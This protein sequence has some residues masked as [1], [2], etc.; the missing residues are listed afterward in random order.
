MREITLFVE[1]VA[2]ETFLR[3]LVQRVADECSVPVEIRFRS[4]RGGFSRVLRELERYIRDIERGVEF[5]PHLLIICTDG[6]CKGY[7]ARRQEIERAI[8]DHDGTYICAIP[9]PHIE[10][11]L[12]LDSAAFKAVLGRGCPAPPK[13]CE[14]NLFKKRLLD[15]VLDAGVRPLIGGLEYTEAIVQAL[16]LESAARADESLARLLTDLRGQFKEWQR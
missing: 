8:G 1:D 4:A 13:K 6:N 12:L 9:D 10:R 3:A 11:W 14:R 15:A 2:H 7:V 5:H 16:N